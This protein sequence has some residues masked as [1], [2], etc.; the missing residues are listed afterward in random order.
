MFMEFA[1]LWLCVSCVWF[2]WLC[3][4]LEEED[5]DDG[6]G[7]MGPGKR[8]P[9]LVPVLQIRL[10]CDELASELSHIRLFEFVL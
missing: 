9:H 7:G 1:N 2:R 6:D 8:K 5:D 10:V 3:V 4:G